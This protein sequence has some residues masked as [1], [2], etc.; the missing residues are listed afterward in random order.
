MSRGAGSRF[1]GEENNQNL[2]QPN[3]PPVPPVEPSPKQT[4]PGQ[5][6]S[7]AAPK[8][9]LS[10][11][12]MVM[13]AAIAITGA[14][15]ALFLAKNVDK[16]KAC[17]EEAKICPDGSAVGR[18]GPKCEFTPCPTAKVSLT[19]DP[20][21]DWKTYTN[22]SMDFMIKY[23]E[24]YKLIAESPEEVTF[25]FAIGGF[26][27]KFSYLTIRKDNHINFQGVQTCTNIKNDPNIFADKLPCFNNKSWNQLEAI[28]KT[29]LDNVTAD[30]VYL[31]YGIDGDHHIIQTEAPPHIEL[32]MYIAGGGLDKIF[33]QILS[34]FKF[35]DQ[36]Q[37]IV[38]TLTCIPRPVCLDAKPP[39]MMPELAEYCPRK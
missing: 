4:P 20:T 13:L 2:N 27:E 31:T 34:T 30:S 32:D 22:K 18:T 37:I 19:P 8:L 9:R 36:S 16:Q 3:T 25:G 1:V 21:A 12:F 5:S 10:I 14:V 17:T 26:G 39:C 15:S 24:G 23:P 28:Q 7:G 6:H 11:F 29:K 35:T 33:D 38:P